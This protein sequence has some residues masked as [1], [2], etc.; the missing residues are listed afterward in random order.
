MQIKPDG[1]QT[2]VEQ[3]HTLSLDVFHDY[4]DIRLSRIAPAGGAWPPPERELLIE[5]SSLPT[6]NAQVGDTILIE[7]PD[8]KQRHMRIAGLAHDLSKGQT[9]LMAFGYVSFDTLEWLGFS[10]DFDE[11]FILVAENEGDKEHV[12]A[13][14]ARVQDR[15]EKSG[16][17]VYWIWIPEPGE[18][19]ASEDL[20]ALLIILGVLG[21]LSLFLSGFLVI[22]IISAL[23]TQQV[24]Q[25]GIMRAIGARVTQIVQ[26]YVGMVLFFSFL[27]LVLAV[28]LGALAAYAFTSFMADLFNIDL[29]GFRIPPQALALEVGVGLMVPLLAAL[30]PIFSGARIT[31][32]EAISSYG[33]G[34]G[35]FGKGLI[36]RLVE[37]V[38]SAVRAM[39]RPIRV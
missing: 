26:L 12:Q 32:R 8:G 11:L 3:W 7:T 38:T 39:S 6:I 23:M 37:G 16:R 17:T 5:R 21:I 33:L 19:P 22:N 35:L 10:R 4:E 28:P 9:S 2:E 25:I 27:A 29:A 34:K 14:A 1:P 31:V 36:D 24:R 20:K 13:V 30:Y 18:H 15:I